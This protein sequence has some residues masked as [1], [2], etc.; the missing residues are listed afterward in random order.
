MISDILFESAE[1]IREYLDRYPTAY[2][3]EMR[4]RIEALLVEMGT[5]QAHLDNRHLTECEAQGVV[6]EKEVQRIVE[7]RAQPLPQGN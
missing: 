5:I 7:H 4:R 2:H 1:E 6:W 3:G